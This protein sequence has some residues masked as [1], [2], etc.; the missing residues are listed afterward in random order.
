MSVF[1]KIL[2]L[3]LVFLLVFSCLPTAAFAD[4]IES[5]TEVTEEAAVDD[6][7]TIQEEVP[8]EE[9]A[10][11]SPEEPPE[12]QPVPEE[13][14]EII[15]EEVSET[16]PEDENEE[17]TEEPDPEEG[18][19]DETDPVETEA[20]EDSEGEEISE[21]EEPSVEEGA[22]SEPVS[23]EIEEDTEQEEAEEKP[24]EEPVPEPCIFMVEL[25]DV[26][27]NITI[28]R[29][30]QIVA[31]VYGNPAPGDGHYFIVGP[32]R[33]E[34]LSSDPDGNT[35]LSFEA[36]T[37]D[38]F[39]IETVQP[40]YANIRYYSPYSFDVSVQNG[41][42]VLSITLEGDTSILVNGDYSAAAGFFPVGVRRALRASG[43]WTPPDAI[44]VSLGNCYDTYSSTA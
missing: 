9:T 2:S 39:T 3:T 11:E 18:P 32:V 21:E 27:D 16:V 10:E 7:V 43:V 23:E 12:E 14:E 17:P 35:R 1:K 37:G 20:P 26:R 38:E 13:S 24:E 42:A 8:A 28:R 31:A 19:K 4:E 22:D 33:L 25:Q 29:N 30:G 36:L 15:S 40:V 5:E 41:A 34:E 6:E 44:Y